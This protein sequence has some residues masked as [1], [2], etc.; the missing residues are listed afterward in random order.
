MMEKIYIK[1]MNLNYAKNATKTIYK[2]FGNDLDKKISKLS[3]GQKQIF[4]ALMMIFGDFDL[5]LIDEF[6][7]SLSEENTKFL[8][9]LMD[10]YKKKAIK[11]FIT[12][13]QKIVDSHKQ[14]QKILIKN[15]KL[16]KLNGIVDI[17]ESI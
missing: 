8:L 16:Q 3:G 17:E 5:L 15:K 10:K 2:K 13:S 9:K 11:I 12:H 4:K 6:E 7:K 14:Y 1:V